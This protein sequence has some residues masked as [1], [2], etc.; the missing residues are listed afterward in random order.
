[1]M[2]TFLIPFVAI[3][4]AG[5]LHTRE[6]DSGATEPTD[7]E[8]A[9]LKEKTEQAEEKGEK[10]PAPGTKIAKPAPKDANGKPLPKPTS[11]DARP[12]VEEG[13]PELS[14]SPEGLM[15]PEG[16]R[17]IQAALTRRGYLPAAHQTGTLDKETSGALRKFQAD[18]KLAKTGSPDRE[19]VRRLG[20]SLDK[21]FR[22]TKRPNA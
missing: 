5:C 6:V 3:A 14:V 9:A 4:C 11:E 16:P 1:M 7:E 8:Q 15:T 19:T 13:R 17:M 12:P 10:P 2:K 21:V 20:I 22:S 18:E